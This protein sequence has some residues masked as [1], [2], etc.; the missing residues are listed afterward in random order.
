MRCR[1]PL[2]LPVVRHHFAVCKSIYI[3]LTSCYT[4]VCVVCEQTQKQINHGLEKEEKQR[5]HYEKRQLTEI[6]VRVQQAPE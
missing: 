1:R 5:E 6:R 4:C 2:H 3:Y